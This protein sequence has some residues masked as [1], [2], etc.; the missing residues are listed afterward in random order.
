[1]VRICFYCHFAAVMISFL[2][3]WFEPSFASRIVEN[4]VIVAL[5]S[6]AC[7]GPCATILA[8]LLS[9]EQKP[10]DMLAIIGSVLMFGLQC[11]IWLP[12]VQ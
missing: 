2:V 4:V 11:L 12:T 6:T 8:A 1:M 9:R 10:S 3:N 7:I 5:L